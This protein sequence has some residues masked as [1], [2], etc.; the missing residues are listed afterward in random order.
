MGLVYYT[1]A[2]IYVASDI[3]EASAMRCKLA[4][5]R[6][7]LQL[8]P[9]PPPPPLLPLPVVCILYISFTA[10]FGIA[11]L[12]DYTSIIKQQ[13]KQHLQLLQSNLFSFVFMAENHLFRAR[14]TIF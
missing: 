9:P 3:F 13:Q 4:T 12:T 6:I 1:G 7:T 10:A 8:L 11:A 14:S 2:L 5:R